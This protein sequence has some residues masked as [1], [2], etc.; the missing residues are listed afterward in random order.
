MYL[1][2]SWIAFKE[3]LEET[4]Y[5]LTDKRFM[6]DLIPFVLKEEETTNKVMIKDKK[7]GIIFDGT[8]LGEALTIVVRFISEAWKIQ[9]VIRVQLLAKSLPGEE[10]A[11]EL[12]HVLSVNYSIRPEQLLQC[13][14]E[15]QLTMLQ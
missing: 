6:L 2:I 13:V 8:R 15:H 3:L 12:I 14:T 11:R 7:L 1:S 4:G 5:R 10:L 9:R